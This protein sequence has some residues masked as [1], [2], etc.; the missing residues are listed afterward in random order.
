[1]HRQHLFSCR[2]APGKCMTRPDLIIACCWP[3]MCSPSAHAINAMHIAAV[4]SSPAYTT[5]VHS[6]KVLHT[7]CFDSGAAV[8]RQ[9]CSHQTHGG[10]S[11]TRSSST[12]STHRAG[13]SSASCLRGFPW[14]G[15]H[16]AADTSPAGCR[17][18]ETSRRLTAG[19]AWCAPGTTTRWATC[20][21]AHA[22]R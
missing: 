14:P 13:H 12:C 21:R 16:A 10:S 9:R 3:L 4:H 18:L 20:S 17:A 6:S 1:M 11:N 2:R 7:G 5:H 22:C 19:P 8:H 15:V